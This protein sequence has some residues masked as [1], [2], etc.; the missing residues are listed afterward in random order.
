MAFFTLQTFV[1]MQ[2][3]ILL[4]IDNLP[5]SSGELMLHC[6]MSHYVGP[7]RSCRKDV[8]VD[9]KKGFW[10]T[11]DMGEKWPKNGPKMGFGAIFNFSAILPFFQISRGGHN[12]YFPHP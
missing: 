6:T 4:Q 8:R 10:P 1:I 7:L 3:T 2:V 11:G 9:R 12:L 5:S